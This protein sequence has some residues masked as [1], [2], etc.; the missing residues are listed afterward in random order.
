MDY[1]P[2]GTTGLYVSRLCFGAMTFAEEGQKEMAWIGTEGQDFAD[3]MIAMALDAGINFF[4]TANMYASGASETMLGKALKGKRH[5]N[6]IA[7]KLYHPLGKTPNSVGTSRLAV[8]REV[9]DSLKRLDTDYID[10]YQV[11]GW[12]DTTPIEETMRALDDCVRQGKVRYIGLSN[13]AA[14]Q[15]AIADGV[16][17]QMGTERFCS[18]QVYYSLVGRDL[19]RDILPALK[20]L[21]MGTMIYSPLAAGFLSGKYTDSDEKGRRSTFSYPPVDQ[22]QGDQVV[23]ALREIAETHNATPSQIALSWV[24]H[25]DG[26]TSVI[27][28]ARKTEQLEDNLAAYDIKLTAE[29]LQKLD[30]VSAQPMQYPQWQPALKRG[31]GAKAAMAHTKKVSSKKKNASA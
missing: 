11:H 21:G 17:R 18:A 7:T 2:L 19:E 13:F 16:A 25:Q 12:D 6:V 15:M 8:M 10:L 1:L 23:Y 27:L 24:L 26:V 5:D 29:E 20:H 3:T 31:Q 14:W 22:V 28:G 30:D 9:E 4:D